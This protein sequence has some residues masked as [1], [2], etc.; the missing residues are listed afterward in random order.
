MIYTN[1]KC[2]GCNKCIRSCPSVIANVA[3]EGRIEVNPDVCIACGACF[4]HCEHGAR[5]FLDDTEAFLADLKAGKKY[6]VI[7]AP[8]F[9]AN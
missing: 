4:D 6:S 2:I 3:V 9:I 1:E 5:D 7:V 8:A